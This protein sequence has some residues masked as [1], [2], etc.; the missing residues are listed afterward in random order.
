MDKPAGRYQQDTCLILQR[1]CSQCISDI[2]AVR[3]R[4]SRGDRISDICIYFYILNK[5]PVP[6]KM[7]EGDQ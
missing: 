7:S 6:D 3:F 5:E 4:T 2:N 1:S